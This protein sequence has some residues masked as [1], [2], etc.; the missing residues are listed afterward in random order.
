[1]SRFQN[2]LKIALLVII[3]IIIILFTVSLLLHDKVADTVIKT[4][5]SN[6]ET[7]I[8]TG[9]FRFSLLRQFPNASVELKN[10][11]VHSSPD[12]TA[13]DF[14]G[15]STDTLLSAKSASVEI[16]LINLIRKDYSIARI[17]IRSGRLNLFTDSTGMNNF[18]IS[19]KKDNESYDPMNIDLRRINL[20]NIWFVYS[21]QKSDL[22]ISGKID[23]ARLKG[24][25]AAKS[26]LLTADSKITFDQ[27]RLKNF[28]VRNHIPSELDIE[29]HRNEYG[30]HFRKSRLSMDDWEVLM[31]G[32]IFKGNDL[33]LSVAGNNINIARIS[34]YLPDQYKARV[35]EYLPSGTL[36]LEGS[37]KGFSTASRNPHVEI[38]FSVGNARVSHVIS[39]TTIENLS[40]N[41]F[42]TNGQENK[43]STSIVEIR[44]FSASMGSGKYKGY[45]KMHDFR[46]P[47]AEL[48][49]TGTVNAAEMSDFLNL[50]LV[51]SVK[52]NVDF[53]IRFLG[54][55]PKKSGYKFSDIMSLNQN[56]RI[57]FRSLGF[58]LNDKNLDFDNI[59]GNVVITDIT[60]VDNLTFNVNNLPITFSGQF[61]NLPLWLAG[62]ESVLYGSGKIS[63]HSMEPERLINK[64]PVESAGRKSQIFPSS[65][66]LDI[67]FSFDTLNYK[68]FTASDINGKLN[69]IS[70]VL[71]FK[72]LSFKSQDGIIS[73]N[74][75]LVKNIDKS[76][77]AKGSFTLDDVNINK[78]F[79]TFNNFGQNFI[80]SENLAGSISGSV[81]V[82]LPLD[83]LFR[84]NIKGLVAEG[85]YLIK[86][87][88]L[89]NF[90]PVKKL[91]AFTQL[92]ELQ[93][94][95]FDEFE[96]DFFIRNNAL[97]IPQMQVRSS[98]AD[99]SVNGKHDFNNTYEYHVKM[100]LSEILSKKARKN[101]ALRSEFGEVEDDGLGRTSVFLKIE[102]TGKESKVTYDLKA[103]GSQ[104]KSDI[105]RERENLGKILDEEYRH[106]S[107]YPSDSKPASKPRF[108]IKWEGSDTTNI[109]VEPED[110]KKESI[111]KKFFKKKL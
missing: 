95:S 88:A 44:N 101:K 75:L 74:G 1:M 11:F 69:Y 60:A 85:K 77:I 71:N 23:N 40:F 56:S 6:L 19:T 106:K 33:N 52:G 79:S 105:K 108:R 66:N 17:T 16:G 37:I 98:A 4:L 8:N 45:F 28:M 80:K 31:T 65:L 7:K 107:T 43:G 84:G 81:S 96:N 93:N 109:Y 48:T 97:Y 61:Q 91:S 26:L 9:S 72:S 94:I 14:P 30:F 67:D 103:A 29:M 53:D 83:S 50:P 13:S 10:V 89:I 92:S 100:L 78:A 57:R 47:S 25:I 87:G 34:D 90:E 111:T 64:K 39:K 54:K 99:L 51:K 32:S 3:P 2:F 104:I 59:N 27:F 68:K 102:G 35:S 42:F 70:S 41:G 55:M 20:S 82:L 46:D 76:L 62:N 73:G 5:N 49:F 58:I 24:N 86:R 36:K 63:A 15:I 38:T 21:D 22:T 110:V 12:F 18:T